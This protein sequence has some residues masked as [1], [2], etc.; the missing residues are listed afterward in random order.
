MDTGSGTRTRHGRP[1]VAAKVRSR[2]ERGGERFWR[3][4]DFSDLPPSA[5]ARALNRLAAEGFIERPRRGLYYRPRQTRFGTSVPSATAIAAQTLQAPLQP[6]GLTAASVLGLTTQNPSTREFV[7]AANNPPEIQM[8]T[9]VTTRRPE[10]RFRLSQREGALLELL[11]ERGR[12]SDLGFAQTR[13][14]LLGVL[15]EGDAFARIT[16]S[17]LDEP[18]RVRAMLGALGQELG[19]DSRQLAKLRKSLNPLSRFDFGPL[20]ELRYARQWQAK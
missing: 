2:I 18:P 20:R 5:V 6:A 9:K 17:A 7:T 11:R 4:R 10:A 13:R 15:G 12:N 1:S 14:R 3:L 8:R 16:R 19:A